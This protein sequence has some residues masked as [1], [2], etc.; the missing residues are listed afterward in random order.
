MLEMKM[1]ISTILRNFSLFD[2]KQEELELAFELILKSKNGIK[3]GID[4]KNL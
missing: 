2:A 4:C 3:V 1:V